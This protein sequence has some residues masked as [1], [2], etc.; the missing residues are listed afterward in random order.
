MMTTF[1][2]YAHG[3]KFVT[4]AETHLK[5]MADANDNLEVNHPGAWMHCTDKEFKW[6]EGNFFD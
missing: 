5:A 2:F 6:I 3:Q 4:E 1:I